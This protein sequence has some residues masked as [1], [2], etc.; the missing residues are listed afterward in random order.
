MALVG[1]EQQWAVRRHPCGA[2]GGPAGGADAAGA[3]SLADKGPDE[4][5]RMLK[6]EKERVRQINLMCKDLK[7][8]IQAESNRA[9]REQTSKSGKSVGQ[10]KF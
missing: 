5:R 8:T 1:A 6:G 3:A 4:L 9:K 7:N 2:D 10:A